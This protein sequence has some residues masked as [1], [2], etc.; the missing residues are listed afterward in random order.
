M[1]LEC[2]T[3]LFTQKVSLPKE[4]HSGQM[5]A[6]LK[7]KFLDDELSISALVS[8]LIAAIFWEH[9]QKGVIDHVWLGNWKTCATGLQCH[10]NTKERKRK[11]KA[12][13]EMHGTLAHTMAV[14]DVIKETQYRLI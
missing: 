4:L 8:K 5:A 1:L 7:E 2:N 12:R 14:K 11:R 10:S 9:S 3:Q 6:H 13:K